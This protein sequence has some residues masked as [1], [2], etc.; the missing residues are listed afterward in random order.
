LVRDPEPARPETAIPWRS[1]RTR[2]RI[3][4]CRWSEARLRSLPNRPRI[5]G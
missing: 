1:G 2:V 3:A 5:C 4:R